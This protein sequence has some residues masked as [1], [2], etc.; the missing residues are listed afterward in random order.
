MDRLVIIL[1]LGWLAY[2][3]SPEVREAV[4]PTVDNFCSER[5]VK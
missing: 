4:D 5:K 2:T 1:L 3:L